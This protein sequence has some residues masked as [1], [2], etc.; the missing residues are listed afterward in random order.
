MASA[1]IVCSNTTGAAELAS[2]LETVGF[3]VSAIVDSTGLVHAAIKSAPDIVVCYE[4]YPTD[5]LFASIATLAASAPRPVVVF[6]NDPD[7]EKIDRATKS[8]IHSY[9]VNGY[10]LHR[11]RSVI[12]VAQAR[13]SRDE[14]LRGELS[15]VNQRFEE[16]KLVDRAK[17]ILMR[18]HQISEDQAFRALRTAAMHSKQRVGQV[19]QQIIESARY[20]EAVNRAGQLRMFSQRIVKLYALICAGIRP[21]ESKGMLADSQDSIS[22]TLSILTRTLSKATFGD[23]IEGVSKPWQ[24]LKAMLKGAPKA[25]LLAEVDRL[26][27]DVLLQAEQLVLNL[28]IAGIATS[29]H[30]INVAGRQRMLSQRLAKQALL[31]SLLPAE[32]TAAIATAAKLARQSFTEAMVYLNAIPLATRETTEYLQSAEAAW[33]GLQEALATAATPAG[34]DAIADLSEELLG[35]FDRLTERYEL[36]M[37]MLM[38]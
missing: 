28:E 31:A 3:P 7:A 12:H 20:G 35:L 15:D 32:A 13:F 10:G 38:K 25:E 19:A 16:R 22:S 36:G 14:V 17:G 2:D 11:L 6:T 18:A 33:V 26:A 1:L 24:Q 23:L 37:Q 4:N 29:L 21:T 5:A 9:V 34:Q 8:G 30:V 27:E